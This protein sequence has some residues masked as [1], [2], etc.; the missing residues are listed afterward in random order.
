MYFEI[1]IVSLT[2]A[3]VRL[4]LDVVDGEAAVAAASLEDYAIGR[5]R[6]DGDLGPGPGRPEVVVAL[7]YQRPQLW[8]NKKKS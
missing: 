4:E 3:N 7:G 6:L 8:V 2:R 5:S 1:I